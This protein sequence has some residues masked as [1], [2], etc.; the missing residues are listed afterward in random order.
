LISILVPER[1]D[2][3]WLTVSLIAISALDLKTLPGE[4]E[5]YGTVRQRRGRRNDDEGKG[6]RR[7]KEGRREGGK[8]G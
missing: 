2:E 5:R 1:E 7:G 4:V 3:G 6:R 8:K